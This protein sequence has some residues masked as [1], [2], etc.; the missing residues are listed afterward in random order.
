MTSSR[1]QGAAGQN[2]RA[3]ARRWGLGLAVAAGMILS[4]A[5]AARPARGQ[6]DWDAGQPAPKQPGE[7][8]AVAP[9]QWCMP[10]EQFDQWVLGGQTRDQVERS[11]QSQLDMQVDSAARTCGLSDAQSRKLTLAAHGD[12]K[13]FLQSIDQLKEKYRQLG[14][15]QQT[16]NKIAQEVLPLQM[17]MQT[18]LFDDASLYRK[19]LVQTLDHGQSLRYEE[20]DRQRRKF[21]YEAKIELVLC[22]LENMIPLRAEQRQ[23]LVKLLLDETQ[24]PKKSGQM[25]FYVVLYQAGKLGEAKLKPLFDDGQWPAFKKMLDQARGFEY[26]LKANGF[27]P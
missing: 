8:F 21:R 15:D 4:A 10:L 3:A 22:N 12:V 17:K 7:Q 9:G 11:L 13:R 18:G 16:F 23:R 26:H 5:L 27:L 14:Q 2:V 19:V 1:G 25:D 6:D 24:P 20:E